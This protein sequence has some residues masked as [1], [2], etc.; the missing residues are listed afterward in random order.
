VVLGEAT[1]CI[2][3]AETAAVGNLA[4]LASGDFD[5]RGDAEVADGMV[6][7]AVQGAGQAEQSLVIAF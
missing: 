1:F 4:A 2:V 3:L 7:V 6:F 5:F